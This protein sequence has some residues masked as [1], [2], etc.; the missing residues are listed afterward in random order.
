M[1][2]TCAWRLLAA[3]LLWA[4]ANAAASPPPVD[5]DTA[6]REG[7]AAYRA[8]DF[9]AARNAFERAQ[10]AGHPDPNVLFNLGLS[11]WQLEA[12]AAARDCFQR[13]RTVPSHAAAALYHLALLAARAGQRDLALHHLA[14]AERA[15]THPGIRERIRQARSRIAPEHARDASTLSYLYL[16]GGHDGNPALVRDNDDLPRLTEDRQYVEALVVGRWQPAP[17]DTLQGTLFSRGY[18]GGERYDQLGAQ[19]QWRHREAEGPDT[20][21]LSVELNQVD[22]NIRQQ[23]I[24]LERWTQHAQG[25]TR[26]TLRAQL[27][28]IHASGDFALL[29]GWRLRGAAQAERPL[30]GGVGFAEWRLAFNERRDLRREDAFFSQSPIRAGL[31]LGYHKRLTS[32]L[33]LDIRGGLRH[34]YFRH[35]NRIPSDQGLR[36]ARRRDTL[37]SLQL[38]AR[39]RLGTRLFLITELGYDDNHS[40]Q[41]LFDYQRPRLSVG[42][43]WQP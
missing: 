41:R 22:R 24:H 17:R 23:L 35:E 26:W 31:Q 38:Q 13:L 16:G 15:S 27:S 25:T 37:Y 14:A 20:T 6:F 21:A 34:S 36:I 32:R 33:S 30:A 8:G 19:L 1:R 10:I 4:A 11:H 39:Q 12:W 7:L 5:A 3:G 9:P 18:A 2:L 28:G 40:G 43:E 42:M 29:S